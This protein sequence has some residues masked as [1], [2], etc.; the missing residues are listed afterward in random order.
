[1]LSAASLTGKTAL[2]GEANR[3]A[4][5][6]SADGAA[7]ARHGGPAAQHGAA[8]ARHWGGAAVSGTWR[9]A[10]AD[11]HGRRSADGARAADGAGSAKPADRAA[12]AWVADLGA[13][14]RSAEVA[15]GASL[16]ST[17]A[18]QEVHL[19]QI[20]LDEHVVRRRGSRA[21]QKCGRD[22]QESFHIDTSSLDV[23]FP[24]HC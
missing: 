1:L 11:T 9:S 24:D 3:A 7:A 21:D 10:A 18:W 16:L 23:C 20:D 19:V 4:G 2:S 22:E 8:A 15:D 12:D 13:G 5:R 14:R 17:L 6:R